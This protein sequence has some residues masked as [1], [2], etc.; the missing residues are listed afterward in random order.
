MSIFKKNEKELSIERFQKLV[1]SYGRLVLNAALR[2]TG[3]TDAAHDVHQEVFLAVWRIWGTFTEETNWPGYLYRSAVR[4]ALEFVRQ[5][6]MTSSDDLG[7]H[8]PVSSERPDTAFLAADLSRRLAAALAGLSEKQ[9][10]AFI[11][12][13]IEGLDYKDVAKM[14]GCSPA[15]VRVHTHRALLHLAVELKEYLPESD[16][17]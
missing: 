11:L 1:E 15:T 4:K 14:L 3:S 16:G 13:R 5:A 10:E 17:D 12:S 2:I 6:R 8:V 7:R 9:A